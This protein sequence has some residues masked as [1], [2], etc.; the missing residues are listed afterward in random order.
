M[1]T[2]E[3]I[4]KYKL[5]TKKQFGQNFLVNRE[6][7]DKIVN[8]AGIIENKNIL[9][10]GPG[11]GGLTYSILKKNPKKLV[12]I[13]IDKD[14]YDILNIE[15]K[16]YKNFNI[17]NDDALKIDEKSLFDEEKI[18]IISNLPYNVG[19]VLLLKWIKNISIFESFTL[20]LQREVVDRIVAK[21][22]TKD[23]SRLTII[24][25]AFCNTKRIFDIKPSSFIPQPKVVS[26]IVHITPK[27]CINNIDFEKLSEI[28]FVLF[29]QRRKK[30]RKIIESLIIE[31]KINKEIIENIDLDKRAEEL[32]IDEFIYLSKN[33]L[34]NL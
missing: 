18:N 13:E 25:Q 10:I 23:Y 29:N 26:S 19:T 11:P 15:F 1:N 16:N 30:I 34:K 8:V 17:I 28:S 12:S 5:L 24:I 21:Q 6:L 33:F 31:N 14:C 9:E 27:N 20:L 7:L 2:L 22:G 3:I 32:S 4:K